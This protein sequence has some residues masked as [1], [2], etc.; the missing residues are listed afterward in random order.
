LVDRDA[1]LVVGEYAIRL[2]S[3]GESVIVVDLGAVKVA[4]T[5]TF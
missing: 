2:I 1:T 4:V 5:V 3:A